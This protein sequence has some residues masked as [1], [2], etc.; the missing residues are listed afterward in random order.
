MSKSNRKTIQTSP[1]SYKPETPKLANMLEDLS[2]EKVI[3]TFVVEGVEFTIIQ[4]PKTFYAGAYGTIND[5]NWK[6]STYSWGALD[7]GYDKEILK[8]IKDSVTPD[9]E[10]TLYVDYAANDRPSGM[11]CGQETTSR[12]QPEGIHVIEAEPSLYIRVKHTHDAYA[13]TKKLT[14]KY[15]HQY[16]MLDLHDL[17]KYL[18]CD[19]DECI[20]E[21]NGSKLNGNEDMQIVYSNDIERYAAVPVKIKSGYEKA[22]VKLNINYPYSNKSPLKHSIDFTKTIADI[23]AAQ[24]PPKEF[25]K[26]RFGEYDWL[27]LEKQNGKALIISEQIIEKRGYHPTKTEI[28]WAECEL[29]SY[30]N[31]KFYNSFSE[32]DKAQIRLTKVIN[33]P[34]TWHGTD[35]G[36]DTDDYIFLLSMDEVVKYFGDSGDWA[37]RKGWWASLE[38]LWLGNGFGQIFFDQYNIARIAKD[39]NGASTSWRT[40]SLGRL[41]IYTIIVDQSGA[42]NITGWSGQSD[43]GIRPAMWVNI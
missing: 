42:C 25:E 14:G 11:L 26:M 17:I 6:P 15:L 28:T 41:S 37:A 1:E 39:T 30:L 33:T 20:Y 12:E 9:C 21:P 18:F 8:T 13:L 40:R 34:Q 22:P 36:A 2:S 4:K 35:S 32:S 27:V 3:N 24:K 7:E 16:H 38:G 31:N 10:I 19:G 43:E 23:E 5:L 29:R